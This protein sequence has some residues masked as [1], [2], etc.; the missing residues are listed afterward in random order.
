[1][2][3]SFL[4][5]G[6]GFLFR[7]Y[8]GLPELKDAH[9][10]NMNVVYGFFRMMFQLRQL[11]PD[12]FVIARDAPTKTKRHEAFEAYK[13]TRPPLPDDLKHQIRLTKELVQ[14]VGIPCLQIDGYEADDI[15]ATLVDAPD[16]HHY[17]YSSD[18]DLKQLVC[19]TVTIVDAMKQNQTTP[20]SFRAEFGFDPVYMLDYLSLIGDAS[21]NVPGVSGI[22]PKTAQK[23][24]AEFQTLDNLYSNLSKVGGT[25]KDKLLY[26]QNDAMQARKLISLMKVPDVAVTDKFLFQPNFQKFNEVLVAKYQFKSLEKGIKE[27]KNSLATPVQN[28]LF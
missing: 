20:E 28:S 26:G 4:I 24:I 15:L 2:K 25:T 18:K 8:Y 17:V 22:G 9:G 19:D 16:L 13:G 7:A 10:H 27:L 14:E 5:D 1:M 3:K 11:K 12:Y 6:S 23:L 21:D